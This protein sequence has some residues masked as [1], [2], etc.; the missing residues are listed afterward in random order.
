[1]EVPVVGERIVVRIAAR[2]R[3]ERDRLSNVRLL[4]G[5][6]E[7][8]R[9]TGVHADR[10]LERVGRAGLVRDDQA[11]GVLAGVLIGL[12]DAQP[13]A[14]R[15]VAEVPL[16]REGPISGSELPSALNVTVSPGFGT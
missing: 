9:R 8:R 15:V 11:H 2:A 6:G 3:V 4:G 13:L 10:L 14:L 7:V 12:L 5:E 1:T 16:E